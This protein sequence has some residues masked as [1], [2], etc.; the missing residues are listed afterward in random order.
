MY[1]KTQMGIAPNFKSNV[2]TCTLEALYAAMESPQTVGICAD[3]ERALQQVKSG[4]MSREEFETLKRDKKKLLPVLTPHATFSDG[5]RQNK[6]AQPSGLS[7]YDI[8]HIQNPREYFQSQVG[9][10]CAELGIVMAHVTPSTE[11]LRLIFEMPEGMSL[12]Q[13]QKWMSQ[14]LDDSD[15]DGSVK[16]SSLVPP[17]YRRAGALQEARNEETGEIGIL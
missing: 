15:Y 2:T 10:R 12:A 3:I 17:L 7:M 4:E 9:N 11:G 13:A 6:T 1:K 5:Q 8:D 16:D 14:Q